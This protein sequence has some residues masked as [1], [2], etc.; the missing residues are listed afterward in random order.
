M[1][2]SLPTEMKITVPSKASMAMSESQSP[3]PIMK[4]LGSRIV[5]IP[6]SSR[7]HYSD[8]KLQIQSQTM[9][10]YILRRLLSYSDFELPH[11]MQQ[12]QYKNNEIP[13]PTAVK[14]DPVQSQDD[15]A[16]MNRLPSRAFFELKQEKIIKTTKDVERC[17]KL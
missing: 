10:P 1:Y 13:I 16:S 6:R 9:P 3:M 11:F 2:L 4:I 8:H 15:S 14:Q 17:I 7:S 12:K 5:D